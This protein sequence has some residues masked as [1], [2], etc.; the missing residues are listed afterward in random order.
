MVV[1]ITAFVRIIKYIKHEIYA[2]ND[3]VNKRNLKNIRY[4]LCFIN[5]YFDLFVT[6][7][8][9]FPHNFMIFSNYF[10]TYTKIKIFTVFRPN[11]C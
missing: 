10:H 9:R 5:I 7:L 2:S 11:C 6:S 3:L 8:S 4:L 1:V